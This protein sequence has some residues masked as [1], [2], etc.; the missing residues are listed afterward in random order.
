MTDVFGVSAPLREEG[1]A[2]G[3]C[4]ESPRTIHAAFEAVA[5]ATPDKTA[6]VFGDE[7]LTFGGPN[8]RANQLAHHL[9][10]L[11]IGPD[12]GVGVAIERSADLIVTLV[13]ILK[14][15]GAYVPVDPGYPL[16]RVTV[17]FDDANVS[18]VVTSA[19]TASRLPPCI[20]HKLQLDHGNN[21]WA[22]A[23]TE[24]PT[25]GAPPLSRTRRRSSSIRR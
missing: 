17:I 18:V 10:S 11:G 6:V 21:Q 7:R 24:N 19:A 25:S 23:S 12:V 1:S 15:G 14:A 3:G 5:A 9:Q 4:R 16:E 13:A 2:D 22:R 8:E 20:R